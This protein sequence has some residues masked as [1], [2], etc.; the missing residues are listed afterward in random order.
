MFGFLG[1]NRT[2]TYAD[3]VE[4]FYRPHRGGRS[5]FESSMEL[6]H[7]MGKSGTPVTAKFLRTQADLYRAYLKSARR[8]V[9][10]KVAELKARQKDPMRMV[11]FGLVFLAGLAVVTMAIFVDYTILEE[12]WSRNFANEFFEV[13]DAL[14][15]SV[16]FKSLQVVFAVLALH[17]FISHIGKVGRGIYIAVLAAMVLTMLVGIGFLNTS[18]S[19]PIGSTL[20]GVELTGETLNAQDELA[21]L[22]LETDQPT[23]TAATQDVA[24]PP[25]GLTEQGYETA[26]TVL[27]FA[28]FGLIFFFVSSVGALSLHYSLEAFTSFTGGTRGER[29]ES[30]HARD[31]RDRNHSDLNM[32][33]LRAEKVQQQIRYPEEATTQ[34]LSMFANSYVE[35]LVTGKVR[36]NGPKR[37]GLEDLL[38]RSLDNVMADSWDEPVRR[39]TEEDDA[40][41]MP[42]IF[43]GQ[44]VA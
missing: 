16:T 11:S 7:R 4:E 28:S 35:G 42:R 12:I 6:A 21:A 3:P 29:A 40:P 31:R 38:H 24:P 8:Q 27:F 9:E 36:N 5:A 43:G 18:T 33:L 1:R 10:I 25:F 41:K 22:G 15:S 23:D 13:P 44:R 30:D 26:K 39:R 20:F 34:F 14:R 2:Q 37:Q 17:Y 32:K 19:L